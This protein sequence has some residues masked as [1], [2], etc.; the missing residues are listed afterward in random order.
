MA[1]NPDFEKWMAKEIFSGG[2]IDDRTKRLMQKAWQEA[3]RSV[4]KEER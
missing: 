1:I 3:M 4:D 2:K